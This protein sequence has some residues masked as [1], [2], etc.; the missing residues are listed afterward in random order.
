[1][2]ALGFLGHVNANINFRRREV[3]KSD[4]PREYGPLYSMNVKFTDQ[5]FGDNLSTDVEEIAA[6]NRLANR[7]K[8]KSGWGRGNY[9]YRGW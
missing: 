8:S 3:M 1:M 4:I 7:L 2:K 9:P 6:V 5:L